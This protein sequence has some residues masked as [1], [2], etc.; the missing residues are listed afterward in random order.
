[1]PWFSSRVS[2]ISLS[3]ENMGLVRIQGL[4]ELQG[5]TNLHRAKSSLDTPRLACLQEPE[6]PGV[7][8]FICK[9]VS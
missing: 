8:T 9:W 5:A 4:Q 2:C 6:A 3:G 1:M 7:H